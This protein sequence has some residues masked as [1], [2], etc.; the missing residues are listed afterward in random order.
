MNE[1]IYSCLVG[2][3]LVGKKED[4]RFGQGQAA[5]YMLFRQ[6]TASGRFIQRPAYIIGS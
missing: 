4:E 5:G 3:I 6:A 2:S 1:L